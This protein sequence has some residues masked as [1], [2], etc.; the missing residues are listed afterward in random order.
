MKFSQCHFTE[1][2]F[3]PPYPLWCSPS[4]VTPPERRLD[5][6]HRFVPSWTHSIVPDLEVVT[7]YTT[8]GWYLIPHQPQVSRTWILWKTCSLRSLIVLLIGC[9]KHHN[10][11]ISS[12][13]SSNLQCSKLP[14]TPLGS[15]NSPSAMKSPELPR[16]VN[17]RNEQTP[18]MERE[19]HLPNYLWRG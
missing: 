6:A 16:V 11:Q 5:A 2:H 12:T 10:F 1:T 9:K 8:S 14:F 7:Y 13:M 4:A 3:M 17:P 18:P 15:P 19:T